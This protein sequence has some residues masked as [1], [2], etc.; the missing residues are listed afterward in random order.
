MAG[1]LSTLARLGF[2]EPEAVLADLERL[3]AWPHA[4]APG[5]RR[6][7]PEVAGSAAP[8]LVARTLAA[9]AAADPDPDAFAARLRHRPGFRRRLVAV[10]AASRSLGGW[11][12][13]HPEEADRLADGR[14]FAAP[15]PV[16]DLVAETT[17]IAS[18]HRDPAAAWDGLRRFKRR[19]LLRVAVRDL[20][21]GVD[22]QQV[23]AGLADLAQACLEAG[24]ALA[25]REAGAAAGDLAGL[26]MGKLGGRE[27]NYVSDIHVL[28][29]H[30]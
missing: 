7:L 30:R 29:C 5:G 20:A 12:A 28:F 19:E 21:G 27:V 26:G 18:R 9:V 24:L 3:G 23:G 1:G 4:A 2:E 16:A 14:R 22:V 11:L 17:A 25:A 10:V 8:R 6:P 13:A 15:R